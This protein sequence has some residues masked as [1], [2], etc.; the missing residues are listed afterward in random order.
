MQS[1]ER[2]AAMASVLMDP[3]GYRRLVL[4]DGWTDDEYADWVVRMTAASFLPDQ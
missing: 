4:G 1:V 3:L 2:A